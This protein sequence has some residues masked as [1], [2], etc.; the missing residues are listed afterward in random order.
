[1]KVKELI[2]YL[3]TVDGE[4]DVVL[5]STDPS[6]YVYVIKIE[7]ENIEV[8]EPLGDSSPYE[9]EVDEETGE[10]IIPEVLLIKV[11]C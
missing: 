10:E 5:Q 2:E 9:V 7:K 1:M 11:D 8:G 4:L 6:D 3:K